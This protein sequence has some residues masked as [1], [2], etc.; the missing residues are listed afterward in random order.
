MK[1]GKLG[2]FSALD[3]PMG[4]WRVLQKTQDVRATDTYSLQHV[5]HKYHGITYHYK[6]AIKNYIC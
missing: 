1:K 4:T 5:S 6:I 3:M 2:D